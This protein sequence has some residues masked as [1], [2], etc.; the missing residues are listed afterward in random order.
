MDRVRS[1]ITIIII[2]AEEE[3]VQT[4]GLAVPIRITGIPMTMECPTPIAIIIGGRRVS[5]SNKTKDQ[6]PVVGDRL[7]KRLSR[8]RTICRN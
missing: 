5:F 6:S 7:A 2:L 3:A 1:T 4:V 8:C